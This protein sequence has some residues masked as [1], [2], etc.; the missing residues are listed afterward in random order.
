MT[1]SMTAK[2]GARPEGPA[3][4]GFDSQLTG[5]VRLPVWAGP[6]SGY[7]G[8]SVSLDISSATLAPQTTKTA[9]LTWM[10]TNTAEKSYAT[11]DIYVGSVDENYEWSSASGSI[12][13]NGA[14]G[15]INMA[16]VPETDL[17]LA[18]NG[19]VVIGGNGM[20]P[21]PGDVH[22]RGSWKC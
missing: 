11:L 22:I 19:R 10:T 17:A 13:N 2:A 4:M 1:G 8:S 12:A 21:G 16:M 18:G 3:L 15:S 6:G 9:A 7:A 14:S 20:V 5:H